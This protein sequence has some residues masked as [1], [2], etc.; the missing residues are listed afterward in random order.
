MIE[1][2]FRWCLYRLNKHGE[3]CKKTTSVIWIQRIFILLVVDIDE[4]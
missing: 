4:S 1:H 2:L 3:S